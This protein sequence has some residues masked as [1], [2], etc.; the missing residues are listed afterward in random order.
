[1]YVYC[2]YFSLTPSVGFHDYLAPQVLSVEEKL[3]AAIEHISVIEAGE[4]ALTIEKFGLERLSGS[5]TAIKF[6]TGFRNYQ[7]FKLFFEAI[8]VHASAMIT[9]SQMQRKRKKC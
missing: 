3:A 9:W 5:S 7:E 8:E 1:M 6:Y 4:A 2:I